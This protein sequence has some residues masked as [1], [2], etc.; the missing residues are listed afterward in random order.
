VRVAP[1]EEGAQMTARA[2]WA[3]LGGEGGCASSERVGAD[4][5]RGL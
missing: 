5:E 1:Y 2:R 3:R 4:F